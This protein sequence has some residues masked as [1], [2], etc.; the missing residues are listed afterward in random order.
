MLLLPRSTCGKLQTPVIL[1][2]AQ[3]TSCEIKGQQLQNVSAMF[4]STAT[5]LEFS[6]PSN[7]LRLQALTAA[8]HLQ[9]LETGQLR[10]E[11][12]EHSLADFNRAG[13]P[14]LEI[15]SEPDMDSGAAAAAYG[16]EIRRIVRFLGV[17]DGNM[18][19]QGSCPEQCLFLSNSM[20]ICYGSYKAPQQAAS[21]TSSAYPTA[22]TRIC[23]LIASFSL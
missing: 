11:G 18:Q 9:T 13:V 21:S 19:V 3:T 10:H 14:L 20:Q 8:P 1:H 7:G 6:C 15:V 5:R 22:N 12:G 17:S 23:I 4:S 2:A 16:A